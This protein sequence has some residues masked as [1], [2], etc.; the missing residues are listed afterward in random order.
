MAARSFLSLAVRSLF[1]PLP[2][3]E[4]GKKEDGDVVTAKI[5]YRPVAPARSTS[6]PPMTQLPRASAT[7]DQI[8]RQ[9]I[10]GYLGNYG[11]YLFFR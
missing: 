4:R 1:A 2:K 10:G 11:H 3:I 6:R 8:S 5:M 9:G 7:D